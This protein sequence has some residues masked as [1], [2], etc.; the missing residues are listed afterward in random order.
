MTLREQ[1]FVEEAQG[2]KHDVYV[3]TYII[4]KLDEDF[5]QRYTEEGV[6]IMTNDDGWSD[7]LKEEYLDEEAHGFKH[8]STGALIPKRDEKGV[9]ILPASWDE[10]DD[11]DWEGYC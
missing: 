2:I 11:E 7:L 8:D 1:Y 5:V 4:R 6:P 3:D 9:A 10:D